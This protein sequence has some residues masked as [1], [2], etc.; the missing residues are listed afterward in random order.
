MPTLLETVTE[1]VQDI[2]VARDNIVAD[3]E[4][5]H[6]IVH[7]PASG[8]GSTVTTDNGDVPTFAKV[9]DDL[10]AGVLDQAVNISAF[11]LLQ[12]CRMS[13][14]YVDGLVTTKGLAV[15]FVDD[16]KI[17]GSST[18]YT[19]VGEDNLV[20]NRIVQSTLTPTALDTNQTGFTNHTV[21]QW[22]SEALFGSNG[23]HVRLTLTAPTN[24][25]VFVT[26][27]RIGHAATS[28]DAYDFAATPTQMLIGGLDFVLI[29][30][31]DVVTTD[32]VA[33]NFDQTKNLIAAIY[34]TTNTLRTKASLGGNYAFYYKSGSDDTATVNATG[35]SASAG[36]LATISK[37]EVFG[38]A[39][40]TL[41]IAPEDVG[42]TPDGIS[43]QVHAKLNGGTLNTH[44]I[45]EITRDNG[46]TWTA[47]TLA[48][49]R[50]LEDGYAV[51]SVLSV[52]VSAQPP[53]SQIAA[54]VKA[55]TSFNIDVRRVAVAGEI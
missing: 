43:V 7:G 44:L 49:L 41:L 31:G 29:E 18:N 10:P 27:L 37:V 4:T 11:M 55:T 14:M 3:E 54:R 19:Y 1:A 35:Y 22:L 48:L 39:A 25:N 9:L 47:A 40:M 42:F 32:I 26:A 23:T 28:G 21:R 36:S 33:F 53:G 38:P 5:M 20:T 50:T 6:D 15:S 51:Y 8:P 16:A 13:D 30:S 24:A 12:E 52:D 17:G 34:A 45:A 46:T 2:A